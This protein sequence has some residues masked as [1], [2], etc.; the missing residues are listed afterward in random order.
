M[1]TAYGSEFY[2]R[3]SEGSARSA[4]QIVPIIMELVRPQSV[5]DVGCGVGTW[6]RAFQDRGIV[7]MLGVDGAWVEGTALRV[8][9]DLFREID[10]TKPFRLPRGFDLAVC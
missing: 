10:L 3:Q 4:E 2:R 1:A 6:L 5:I 8:S 9:P 7:D